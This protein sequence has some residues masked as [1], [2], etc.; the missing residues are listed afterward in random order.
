MISFFSIPCIGA[1]S[2]ALWSCVKV[3][4]KIREMEEYVNEYE[5]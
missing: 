2:F 5:R 1:F 4:V 3:Y